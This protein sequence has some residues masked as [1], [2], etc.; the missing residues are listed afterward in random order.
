M[1]YDLWVIN[2]DS[3]ICCLPTPEFTGTNRTQRYLHLSYFALS[4]KSPC[5]PETFVVQTACM[6]FKSLLIVPT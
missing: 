2:T 6:D 3:V 5:S 4:F 1:G